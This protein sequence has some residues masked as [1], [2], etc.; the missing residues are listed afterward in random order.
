MEVLSGIGRL[1]DDA[2]YGC[3]QLT[4][5]QY[6]SGF[7]VKIHTY[8]MHLRLICEGDINEK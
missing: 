2:L 6:T 8:A 1:Q 3:Q 4:D 5:K 7:F